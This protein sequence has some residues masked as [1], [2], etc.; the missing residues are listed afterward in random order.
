MPATLHAGYDELGR[1]NEPLLRSVSPAP[2]SGPNPNPDTDTDPDPNPIPN[3][4]QVRLARA[5]LGRRRG[6][7]RV[8]AGLASPYPNPEALRL[9]SA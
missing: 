1:K 3:P 5:D 7:A 8:A 6:T 4:D 2:T 9:M